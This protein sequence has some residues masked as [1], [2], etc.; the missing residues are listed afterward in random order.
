MQFHCEQYDVSTFF[1]WTK[2]FPL[3][4]DK[5]YLEWGFSF[6]PEG[7]VNGV[8]LGIDEYLNLAYEPIGRIEDSFSFRQQPVN[9]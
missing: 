9:E 2:I 1:A 8:F 6:C 4:A 7:R 3:I 5:V